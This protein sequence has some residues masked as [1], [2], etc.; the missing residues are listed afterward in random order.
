MSLESSPCALDFRSSDAIRQFYVK[1]RLTFVICWK[2]CVPLKLEVIY[3]QT[4]ITWRYAVPGLKSITPETLFFV[5]HV[6]N[7]T[8]YFEYMKVQMTLFYPVRWHLYSFLSFFNAS[9]TQIFLGPLFHTS[10][11][12][13]NLLILLFQYCSYCTLVFLPAE[14]SLIENSRPAGKAIQTNKWDWFSLLHV[15]F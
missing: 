14:L 7:I 11:C 2:S 1:N 8:Q 6:T 13:G 4:Y 15:L 10:K 5:S 9:S 12:N 3:F